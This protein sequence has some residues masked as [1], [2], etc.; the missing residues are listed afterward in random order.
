MIEKPI[1]FTT[2]QIHNV[3]NGTQTQLRCILK[4]MPPHNATGN[5]NCSHSGLSFRCR[6]RRPRRGRGAR[7]SPIQSRDGERHH[8]E[9][10][11]HCIAA[12]AYEVRDK[13]GVGFYN[14]AMERTGGPYLFSVRCS[15]LVLLVHQ[16][17]SKHRK[18]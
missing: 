4:N 18:H 7:V 5:P 3:L 13:A 15:W 17:L 6:L 9:L 2:S 1:E 16:G 11:W 10:V 12:R 8:T 14:C